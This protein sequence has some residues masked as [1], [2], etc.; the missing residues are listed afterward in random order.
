VTP[1]LP[2]CVASGGR[3]PLTFLSL[4]A[5]IGGLD[6]GLERASMRCIGQVEI[7]PFCRKVL[8]KHW[9]DVPR[10]DDVRTFTKDTF[11]ERPDVICGGFPCQDISVGSKTGT[12]LDGERSGLWMEF[13]RLIR[14]LRPRFAI[15]E[16]SAAITFRGFG[17]LLSDLASIGFDAEWRVFAAYEFGAPH[18]RERMYVVAYANE[19]D[20]RTRLGFKQDWTPQ[21]FRSRPET[22]LPIWLQA[23]GRFIGMDDGL[24]ARAYEH[25]V[26]ALGNAVV[27]QVAEFIGNLIVQAHARSEAP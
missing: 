9:P 19:V 16:N 27:P 10:H 17:E 12:G 15:V 25:R 2:S 8:A 1:P 14:E 11:N 21:I 20:G 13:F 5:G 23:T 22:R 26:G 6:L 4:F 7:D 24:S 3:A 18:E